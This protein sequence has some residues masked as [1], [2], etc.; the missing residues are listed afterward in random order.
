MMDLTLSSADQPRIVIDAVGFVRSLINPQ[1]V[2]GVIIFIYAPQYT[3]VISNE[4][5]A[6]IRD[7]L[8]RPGITRKFD[9]LSDDLK[10]RFIDDADRGRPV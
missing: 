3:L 10:S 5:E 1:S 9:L 2:W 8:E 6:E 4:I 7:V